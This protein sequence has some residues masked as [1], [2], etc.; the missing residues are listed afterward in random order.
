MDQ[1][2]SVVYELEQLG[3]EQ[4]VDNDPDWEQYI[5]HRVDTIKDMVTTMKANFKANPPRL[6]RGD[7]LYIRTHLSEF[8]DFVDLVDQMTS[9]N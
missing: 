6:T 7:V 9:H 5:C 3:N 4:Y 1:V 2:K 8:P